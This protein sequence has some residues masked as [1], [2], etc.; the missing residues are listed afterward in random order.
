[1]E[2]PIQARLATLP[3]GGLYLSRKTI[4]GLGYFVIEILL[5]TEDFDNR[6]LHSASRGKDCKAYRG[7]G[8]AGSQSTG[9]LRPRDSDDS[10]EKGNSTVI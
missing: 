1:M 4:R 6:H 8:L 5:E 3:K 7:K 9:V 10:V 2:G